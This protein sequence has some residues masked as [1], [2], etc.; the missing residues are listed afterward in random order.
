MPE[1]SGF[2]KWGPGPIGSILLS[3]KEFANPNTTRP[4]RTF[5]ERFTRNLWLDISNRGGVVQV[6]KWEAP[7]GGSKVATTVMAMLCL[8]GV[9]FCVRFLM[10]LDKECKATS[11]CYWLRPR[12]GSNQ[13][14]IPQPR[15]HNKPVDRAAWEPIG[16][17]SFSDTSG[18]LGNTNRSEISK[19]G[20]AELRAALS[21][22]RLTTYKP[23][24]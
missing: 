6:F 20:N 12:T 10:A 8:A 14:V 24:Y 11:L 17:G 23:I 19:K 21:A 15:E 13:D 2:R 7:P 1:L 22:Y 3:I 5:Y 4:L 18:T 16:R 9:A